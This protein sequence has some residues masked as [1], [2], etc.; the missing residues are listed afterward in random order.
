LGKQSEELENI[1]EFEEQMELETAAA[2]TKKK[3]GKK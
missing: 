1:N 2:K 3:R